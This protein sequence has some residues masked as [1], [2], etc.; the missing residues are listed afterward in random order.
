ML[1]A[2]LAAAGQ[3]QDSTQPAAIAVSPPVVTIVPA[4]SAPVP[5]LV[6]PK[7]TMVR[8]MVL[9]EVNSRDHRGGHRFV[10]RVDEE[11][12]V[13]GVTIIPIG[14]NAW[15]EVMSAQGTGSAGKSGTLDARLLHVEANGRQVPLEGQRQ[16]GGGNSTGA[17]V[18][19]VIAFGIFGL[20]TKGSNAS[21]KAGEILNGYTVDDERFDRP[22]LAVAK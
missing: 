15:G 7:G 9:N 12:T 8:L 10:L 20:L 14:A 6:L 4:A 5:G 3:Q 17:V 11:V 1:A 21:L 22:T 18:A 2:A 13:G 19:G 16:A